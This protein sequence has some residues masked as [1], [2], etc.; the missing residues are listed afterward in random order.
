MAKLPAVIDLFSGFDGR[1][2]SQI[3]NVTRELRREGLLTQGKRGVGAP[4]MK[5][6]DYT[7]LLFSYGA[8]RATDAAEC[9]RRLR[10]SL[11]DSEEAFIRRLAFAESAK[12]E[13]GLLRAGAFCDAM[14]EAMSKDLEA[15]FFFDEVQHMMSHIEIN[16]PITGLGRV[17]F[18]FYD[19]DFEYEDIVE[20][21]YHETGS[22]D[23]IQNAAI[24]HDGIIWKITDFMRGDD[25]QD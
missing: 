4:E 15:T 12:D 21:S 2:R 16:D 13:D 22:A 5:V 20:F 25:D 1:E 14:L 11:L 8:R 10:Y 23:L 19:D 9:V 18:T 3:E 17:K 7:N 6:S 24:I